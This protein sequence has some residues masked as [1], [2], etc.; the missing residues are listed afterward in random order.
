MITRG[1]EREWIGEAF[2]ADPGP[3]ARVVKRSTVAKGVRTGMYRVGS[4]DRM[5]H[6]A[7]ARRKRPAQRAPTA[8]LDPLPARKW[9][10]VP[11]RKCENRATAPVLKPSAGLEP[12]TP[13]LPWQS[14]A[15]ARRPAK[16][17]SAC[18]GAAR[19]VGN[20]RHRSAPFGILRYRVSTVSPSPESARYASRPLL[21]LG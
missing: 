5:T 3:N 19:A 2:E 20:R 1:A 8:T 6:T 10:A 18:I 16:S 4:F 12:A 9:T 7:S 15:S 11:L 17:Q 14:G 21:G 13:S